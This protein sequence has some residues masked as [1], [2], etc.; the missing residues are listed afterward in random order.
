M[1]KFLDEIKFVIS[2]G[3]G[4]D[5]IVSFRRE[6]G[7]PR[8]GPDGGAGG[9][10]GDVIFVVNPSLNT[11]SHLTPNAHLKA[12]D[13]KRG[14]S[15]C[16]HG[17]SGADLVIEVPQGTKIIK[18]KIVLADLTSKNDTFLALKGGRGGRGNESFKSS[19]NQAPRKRELGKEGV[20]ME[21]ALELNLIADIGFVGFPNAG[22]SSLLKVLTRA[23]PRIADYAFTTK[24]PNLGVL[25][26][27]Y[28]SEI[29]LADIPGLLEGASHGVG[30]GI[31]FLKHIL[32][33]KSLAFL[34]D[35][36]EGDF[37]AAFNT[38]SLELSK[39][40]PEFELKKHI[41]VGTK[42]D[43]HPERED[44]FLKSFK[45]EKAIVISSHTHY[46]IDK[47]IKELEAL[48]MFSS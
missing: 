6:K 37:T 22:K 5:G 43:L 30:L 19:T 12:Q 38:L 45:N 23:N 41:I 25:R 32:R 31:E 4:G 28:D 26:V 17:G 16:M 44:A 11:L 8:G 18:D 34:I 47:L 13:G 1:S 46:N 29:V 15:K 20:Q 24:V 10:G 14:L 40:S 9:A 35:L 21:V 7:V 27:N 42:A 2:S 48:A 3:K 36:G 33:T 39:F